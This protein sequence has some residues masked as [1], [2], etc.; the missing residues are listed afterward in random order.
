M[1]FRKAS[2]TDYPEIKLLWERVFLDPEEFIA[3]FMA[4]FGIESGYVCEINGN[5]AAM[6]FALPTTLSFVKKCKSQISNLKS[7]ITNLPLRYIYACATHPHYRRQGIM[8]ILI[9]TIYK[10]AR[11]ENIA[12]IF[13]RAADPNLE[14]Y[15][16]KLG[17]EAFFYRDVINHKEF[18]RDIN[19]LILPEKYHKKR[20]QKL[21]GICFVNWDETFFKFL[22]E[23]GTKF[24]ESNNEIIAFR[25]EKRAI[26][27]DEV[28]NDSIALHSKNKTECCGQMRWCNSPL[29][30][31]SSGYFTFSME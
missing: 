27:I 28:L 3:C 11:N 18:K 12:G 22:Y 1:N 5:I 8:K 24:C 30:T 2:T 23:T 13:L 16:R 15:Y 29:P 10:E 26:M 17:F 9:E 19:H 25:T 6:A 7:Q 4:H 20:V 31:L 21:E 14:N